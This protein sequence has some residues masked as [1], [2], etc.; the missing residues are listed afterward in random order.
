MKICYILSYRSPEYVR[1]KTLLGALKQLNNIEVF[2]AVNTAKGMFRYVQTLML[3]L[4][5]K[6]TQKPECYILGFRGYE[7]FWIVRILTIGKTLVFDHMMS[8]YD[9]LINEKKWIKKGSFVDK[10]LIFL[11]EKLILRYSDIILTDTVLHKKY[12]TNLFKIATEKIIAIPVGADEAIF[13]QENEIEDSN[14]QAYF[15]VLFYGS[16]LPLH[17]MD[18]ILKSAQLLR[19]YPIKF[20]IIGGSH[21]NLKEFLQMKEDLNLDN[22]KHIKWIPIEHLPEIINES[23][24]CLGGPFGNTGQAKRVVT[25]KTFQALAMAKPV[26]VGEIDFDYGFIN[27]KNCLLVKQSSSRALAEIILWCTQN[28]EKLFLIGKNGRVL[29]LRNFSINSIKNH[30]QKLLLS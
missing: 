16:F 21:K 14:T 11:Y 10:I 20:T 12:F 29:Y 24:I 13:R 6:K 8:P 4:Y 25:G 5:I 23:D 26:V 15:N 9:S 7:I 28:R 1:T 30:L 17:G 3:L 22:V 18:V 19:K 2:E 27:K